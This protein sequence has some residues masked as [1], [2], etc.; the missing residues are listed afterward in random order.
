MWQLNQ[1]WQKEPLA[2]KISGLNNKKKPTERET[3]L[4]G[5]RERERE[6][7]LTSFVVDNLEGIE[8]GWKWNNKKF[9]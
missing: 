7:V 8:E 5:E 3:K 6:R 9:I 4:G 2:E 1:Q